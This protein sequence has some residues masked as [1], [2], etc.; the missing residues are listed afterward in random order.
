M[1]LEE[2]QFADALSADP[3]G[4]EIGDAAGF[5]FDTDVGYVYFAGEDRQSYGVNMAY[6]RLHQA[7]YDVEIV[8]HEVE[9]DVDIER[10]WTENAQTMRL[11]KHWPVQVRLDG[12]DGGIE[13]LEMSDLQ[14][15]VMLPGEVNQL[16]S[17]LNIGRYGFFDEQIDSSFEKGCCYCVVG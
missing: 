2:A 1:W 16:V 14:D 7:E 6:R 3:A 15:A 12:G 8:D 5:E 17:F 13:P 9:D 11:E 4:C 10:A